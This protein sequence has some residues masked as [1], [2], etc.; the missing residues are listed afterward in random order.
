LARIRFGSLT[1][2]FG[3]RGTQFVVADGNV[4]LLNISAIS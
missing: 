2:A 1:A 3:E 4:H